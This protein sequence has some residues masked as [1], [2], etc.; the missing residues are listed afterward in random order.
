MKAHGLRSM[1]LATALAVCAASASGQ[2][3]P[4]QTATMKEVFIDIACGPGDF[5]GSDA[6][7]PNLKVLADTERAFAKL[8][9]EKGVRESFMAYFAPDGIWFTPHP[10]NTIE[11][12]KSRPAPTGP[13]PRRLEWAPMYGDVAA[14][15]DLGYDTGPSRVTDLTEKREP[16]R[17][18]Y[19]FSIWKKQP[20]GTWRVVLDLGT[21]NPAD[22]WDPAQPPAFTQAPASGYH[23]KSAAT[24][25]DGVAQ[26]RSDVD[27]LLMAERNASHAAEAQGLAVALP[28]V[29]DPNARWHR[30]FSSPRVG[31]AEIRK[32]LAAKDSKAHW[33]PMESYVAKSG[34]LSYTY[35]KYTAPG[36]A[37][38]G[39]R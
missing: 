25:R 23:A 15:G 21:Q 29:L 31:I 11:E 12:L 35:G 2:T 9:A 7:D 24:P 8:G 4:A 32:E 39:R 13:L 37:P 20:D 30:N 27:A 18:G 34:D 6:V 5:A 36:F 14:S 26:M 19:F 3:A 10:K 16:P 38:A 22:E 17:Y 33:E 28:L 1:L